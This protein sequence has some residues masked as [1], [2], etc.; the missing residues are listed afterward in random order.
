[1]PTNIKNSCEFADLINQSDTPV[2]VDF[3]APWCGP[4]KSLGP[5][6]EE[7][8]TDLGDAANIVKIN[9]DEHSDLAKAYGITSIP[10]LLFFS[11]GELKHR[12]TG[13]APKQNII[14]R[15]HQLSTAAV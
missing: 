11:A 8:A 6:L 2:V 7:V 10:T 13:V 5:I 14:D 1:M 9:V 12:Q 3:W 15:V 4:C